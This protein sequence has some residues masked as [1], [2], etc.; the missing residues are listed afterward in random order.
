MTR[1]KVGRDSKGWGGGIGGRS[2]SLS[3]VAEGLSSSDSMSECSGVV[4][5]ESDSQGL[6]VEGDSDAERSVSSSISWNFFSSGR[7]IDIRM[8]ANLWQEA[9]TVTRL[10]GQEEGSQL[11]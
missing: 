6:G 4:R 9:P 10:P 11:P 3:C 8:I 2:G 1:M 7:Y 5:C